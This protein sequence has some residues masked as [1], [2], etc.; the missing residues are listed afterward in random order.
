VG[1]TLPV[2]KPSLIEYKLQKRYNK[3]EFNY[4]PMEDQAMGLTGLGGGGTPNGTNPAGSMTNPTGSTP[5]FGPSGSPP[6]SPTGGPTSN[7]TPPTAP[8]DP[9]SPQQ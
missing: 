3:W 4:D 7:P 2:D 8:T 6:G 1:F 5:T 9:T